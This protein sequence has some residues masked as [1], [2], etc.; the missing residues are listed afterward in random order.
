M[1][2]KNLLIISHTPSDNTQN[3]ADSVVQGASNADTTNTVIRRLSP[4]EATA[5]D[6]MLADALIIG[7]I[8]N[9]GY[10]SGLTKDLFDRCYYPCLDNTE[11]LPVALYIRAGQDGTGTVRSLQS[12]FT[13]LR[14]KLVQEPLI[15]KGDFDNA[16]LKEC[17]ELGQTIAISLDI[18]II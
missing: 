17:E 16:F 8:E 10:M 3:M 12:I 4:I 11:G 13:G 9:L 1:K 7:T 14:W 6:I 18:G 2:K 15:C 5:T